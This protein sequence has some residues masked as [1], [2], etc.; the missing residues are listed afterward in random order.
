MA[1]PPSLQE[2][3]SP[4]TTLLLRQLWEVSWLQRAF[5]AQ[6]WLCAW[7]WLRSAT[8]TG[9]CGAGA[10]PCQQHSGGAR[11]AGS[12]ELWFFSDMCCS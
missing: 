1:Q 3:V 2:C 10:A 8:G 12:G 11:A 6:R 5:R 9:P 4:A 7:L